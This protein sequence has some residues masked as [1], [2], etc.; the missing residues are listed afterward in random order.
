MHKIEKLW[1]CIADNGPEEGEGIMGMG[2]EGIGMM[3]LCTSKPHIAQMMADNAK[4]ISER[5]GKP[6][7]VLEFSV[8]KDVTQEFVK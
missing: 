5:S 1:A 2:F 6:F 7:K 8:I 3:S 4:Q